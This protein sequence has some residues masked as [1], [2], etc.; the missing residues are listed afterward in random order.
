MLAAALVLGATAPGTAAA[1]PP[2]AAHVL[3]VTDVGE[4][5][6]RTMPADL[7][8]KLAVEYVGAR[9]VTTEDGTALPDEAR[10]RRDHALYAVLA[11]F[12]RAMRLPGFAQDTSRAYGIARFTV[13]NCLTGTVSPIKTVRIESDP[14]S[15]TE[16]DRD[17][18][19]ERT[20]ARATR[21]TLERDPLLLITAVARIVRI[22]NGIVYLEN[23]GGFAVNQVLLVVDSGTPPHAPIQL[24]ML[25]N[26]GRYAQAGVIRNLMPRVGDYVEAA[27]K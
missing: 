9:S 8:R 18:N 15:D 6:Q 25:E 23:G 16:R 3:V 27:S 21:A 24:V 10:C 13:R 1:R 4:D 12:E 19:A 5:A 11:T 17:A 7:W 14:I 26:A 22:D 20:W 2:V